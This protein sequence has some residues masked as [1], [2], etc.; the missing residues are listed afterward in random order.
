[1]DGAHQVQAQAAEEAGV[2]GAVAVLGPAGQV[3]AHHRGA[4]AG[5]FD[6]GGVGRPDGVIGYGHASAQGR[7]DP[8][9][10]G[11]ELADALVVAR[12]AGHP[13]EHRSQGAV[14][15]DAAQPAGLAGVAQQGL[16]DGQG[17]DLG[18]AGERIRPHGRSGGRLLGMILQQVVDGD[19]QC[20]GEGLQAGVH[21][22]AR[23]SRKCGEIWL[24]P[25]ILRGPH[26][27]HW[28]PRRPPPLGLT[29]LVRP[30]RA[31]P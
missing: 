4:R 24:A 18:V 28:L 1:M 9:H 16:H 19:A 30:R 17:D 25:P 29:H 15:P 14:G 8:G 23:P 21:E 5:A 13:G 20:G 31:G 11:G 7:G 26:P 2:G 22:R 10:G 12:L 6:G 3:R 27:I